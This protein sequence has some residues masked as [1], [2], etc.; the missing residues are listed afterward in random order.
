MEIA[1]RAIETTGTIDARQR[2]VLDEDLPIKGP[3]KVRVIILYPEEADID[4]AEWLEAAS[5]NPAFDFLKNPAEDIYSIQNG[6]PF[7]NKK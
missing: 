5:Q 6:K 1:S 7:N 3:Q 4:E 2:L